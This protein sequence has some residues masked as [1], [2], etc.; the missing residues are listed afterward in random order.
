MGTISLPGLGAR[1]PALTSHLSDT[2][3][4]PALSFVTDSKVLPLQAALVPGITAHSE[5]L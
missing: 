1:A 2:F 4:F 3:F 5:L